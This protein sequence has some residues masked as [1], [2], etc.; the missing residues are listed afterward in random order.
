M[1][2]TRSD[3]VTAALQSRSKRNELCKVSQ[4]D[5]PSQAQ[6]PQSDVYNDD[7]LYS[8]VI[9]IFESRLFQARSKLV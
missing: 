6:K 3:L 8:S 2:Q 5:S 1:Q 7:L 4:K 9:L